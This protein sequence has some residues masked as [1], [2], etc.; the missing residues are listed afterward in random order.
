MVVII[1]QSM[2]NHTSCCRSTRHN[3]RINHLIRDLTIQEEEKRERFWG[4]RFLGRRE[5]AEEEEEV[6]DVRVSVILVSASSLPF[7][8][9]F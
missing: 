1:N 7:F 4:F 9:F 6:E 5:D 8:F 2:K 3:E